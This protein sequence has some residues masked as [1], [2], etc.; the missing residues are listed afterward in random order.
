MPPLV[1]PT[2]AEWRDLLSARAQLVEVDSASCHPDRSEA[3][4]RDLLSAR[5]QLVEFISAADSESGY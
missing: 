2:E 1:I 4:W 3:E 5:A